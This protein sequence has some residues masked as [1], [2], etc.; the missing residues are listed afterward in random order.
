MEVEENWDRVKEVLVHTGEEPT[1]GRLAP[2]LSTVPLEIKAAVSAFIVGVFAVFTDLDFSLIE[3]NPWTLLPDGS[4]F[5][6]DMRGVGIFLFFLSF[7]SSA[8]ARVGYF[9]SFFCSCSGRLSCPRL[10]QI[11]KYVY[12]RQ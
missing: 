2:L 4:P 8:L 10:A 3:M 1:T 9:F 6:L 12:Y 11:I 7:L 5:P